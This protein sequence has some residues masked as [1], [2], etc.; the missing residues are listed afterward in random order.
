MDSHIDR[1]EL[2]IIKKKKSKDE[3]TALAEAEKD[4][5]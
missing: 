2:D 5:R 3:L 4:L 1:R